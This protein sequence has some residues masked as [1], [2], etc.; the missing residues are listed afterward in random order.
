MEI[1]E[2][3]WKNMSGSW[4]KG[5]KV[6][7]CLYWGTRHFRLKDIK[8]YI[9]CQKS[10][11]SIR[12]NPLFAKIAQLVEHIHGKDEVSGSIPDLGSKMKPFVLIESYNKCKGRNYK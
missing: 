3:I 11:S 2:L 6:S 8:Y 10:L 5:S 12:L 4:M 7:A 1:V 9:F